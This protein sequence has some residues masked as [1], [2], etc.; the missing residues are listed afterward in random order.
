[1]KAF[2]LLMFS[3]MTGSL[4]SEAQV[5]TEKKVI[6]MHRSQSLINQ[7]LLAKK[8]AA[9]LNAS[10]L[11]ES[12]QAHLKAQANYGRSAE[13]ST[14]P[15][16]PIISPAEDWSMTVEKRLQ[17]GV[18][19][20]AGVFGSQNSALDNS[21][22][23]ATQVGG[24]AQLSVDLWKNFLG[25]Q[26]QNQTRSLQAQK[27]RAD[28]DY[29]IQKNKSEVEIR[30]LFWSLVEVDQS[31]NLSSQ[32]L[33]SAQKQLGD[34]LKRQGAGVAD[35]G[36]V[37][38]YRS[39]VDSRSNSILLFQYEKE[40]LFQAFEKQWQQFQGS[41]WSVDI[42]ESDA[43]QGAVQ[44]CI[45]AIQSQKNP[46]LQGTF[47][48]EAV[49]FLKEE[50]DAEISY[51]KTH[52]D[53]DLQFLARVQ[54]TGVANSYSRA[55]NDLNEE[56]RA[57]YGLGLQ[58]I[59]PLGFASSNSEDAMLSLKK[60]SLEAQR[61]MLEKEL[62]STH[63]TM[64]KALALL[65]LG[66]KNQVQNSQNLKVN[67]QEVQRKFQQGRV[68]VSTVVF[69]QD[70]LFQSQLQEI[71]FQRQL[72]HAVLDYFQVFNRFNCGWNQL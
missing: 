67:Y 45:A 18:G 31:I 4:L 13:E 72:A 62:Q 44:L 6:E 71:T 5:L 14:N 43:Q 28:L 52:A 26:D 8:S 63:S 22:S 66:L 12:F 15:F 59:I 60:N 55:Q 68:P 49:A 39:Q 1:M 7:S 70:A 56:N 32:L 11:D 24:R 65:S 17:R 19:I 69:E 58:L 51:A 50:T 37:A 27:K 30:K 57:G 29:Q 46:D 64:V 20:S 36:E 3:F 16:Q 25:R 48:D 33:E 10:L 42:K 41:D 54:T 34:A 38:R 2:G 61:L 9:D 35:R 40:L 47:L 23:N 53:F 21:F